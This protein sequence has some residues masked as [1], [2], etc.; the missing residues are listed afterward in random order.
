MRHRSGGTF[1]TATTALDSV[2]AADAYA[3]LKKAVIRAGCLERSYWFYAFLTL[4]AFAGYTLSVWAIYSLQG[5]AALSLGCLGFSFFSVQVAGLMHDSGHRAVFRS[6]RANDLLGYICSGLLGMAFDNWRL[7]H[8]AHHAHPNELETDPDIK[9]PFIATSLESYQGKTRLERLLIRFQAYY[10]FPLGSVVSLS[11][12]LGTASYFLRNRSSKDAWK[13]LLYLAGVVFLF[14]SPFV[15]FSPEKAVFV[16]VLVHVSSGVYLANCF[17]P[18]HKGM[19]QVARD[20]DM[21]FIEQQVITSRNIRGGFFTDVAMVGLNYQIEHHLF[22]SC[23]RNKLK[24]LTP[25]VQEVC[26]RLDLEYSSVGI[27]ETNRIILREL[28][29]VALAR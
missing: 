21:S 4:F 22:P 12:R 29:A 6:V 28:H 13:L 7:N 14:I 25:F 15:A 11:N 3:E 20:A 5:Y 27:I 18:N 8:N 23:P 1:L 16:L 9:I 17:A 26:K 24:L 19:P 2:A 10:F